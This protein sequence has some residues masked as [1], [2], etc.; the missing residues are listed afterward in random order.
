MRHSAAAS[1][2]AAADVSADDSGS[3]A[4]QQADTGCSE[5]DD[6]GLDL[7]SAVHVDKRKGM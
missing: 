6:C 2:R 5:L 7:A 3:A 4:A 1:H